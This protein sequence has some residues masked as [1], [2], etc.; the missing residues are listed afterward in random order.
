M[1]PS[2]WTAPIGRRTLLTTGAAAGFV[3]AIAACGASSSKTSATTTGTPSPTSAATTPSTT[4]APTTTAPVTTTSTSVAPAPPPGTRA[5]DP[6]ALGVASGDPTDTA[7]ILWTRV[8]GAATSGPARLI[9]EVAADDSFTALV[10]S[11]TVEATAAEGHCVKVDATG[12]K[13]GRHYAYRFRTDTATTGT[14]TAT[15][16]AAA[17]TSPTGRTQ[18]LPAAEAAVEELRFGFASCQDYQAGFY[19]AHD[20]IAKSSLDFVVWLGNYIYEYAAETVDPANGVVRSHSGGKL[21]TLDDYRSRYAQYRS[22]A[23]LQAA[24]AS[25]PWLVI[26][27]DHEVENNYAND[28]SEDPATSKADFLARRALAYQAWWEHMPV[29][30][31]HPSGPALKIYRELRYGSLAH[32]FLLDGRQYRSD[33]ACGDATLSLAPPCPEVNDPN[34][35]MLGTEQEAWLLAGLGSSNTTWNIVGNQ[36]VLADATLNGAVLNFDMWDGYPAARRRLLEGIAATGRTNTVVVTGDIHLAAVADLTIKATDGSKRIVA[37]EL[38]GTSI[39]SSALLPEGIEAAV[40]SFPDLRYLN[41]RKRGW[42]INVV[43]ASGW[44]A[45]YRTVDDVQRADSGVS[46]DATFTIVPSRAGATKV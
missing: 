22:D 2:L 33:Q 20:D 43:T 40:S 41:A 8:T 3:A 10:A 7:V 25:C 37:T 35:T 36:V 16:T 31:P 5:A 24:H 45:T 13:A 14:A 12:L 21:L 9:W 4:V 39:S 44:T 29:R 42:T 30:L 11:G 32:V 17:A 23:A 18:T 1:P 19:A 38:V 15:A 28:V 46:T 34:R 6:F 26:W 27:D